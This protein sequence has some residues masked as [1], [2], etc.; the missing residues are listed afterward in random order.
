MPRS[1]FARTIVVGILCLTANA[2]AAS[3]EGIRVVAHPATQPGNT[4]YV[5]NRA[6]LAPSPLVKLPIGSIT[7]RGWLAHQLDMERDGMTGH[8]PEVSHWCK[9][10]GNAWADPK[11]TGRNGW[12]EL[13]YWL[14]G[15]IDL[16]YVTHDQRIIDESRKW[17]EAILASQDETGWFGP[18]FGLTSLGGKPDLWPN[19]PI[20]NVL[21]SYY[22]VTKDPRVLPFMTKYFRWELN[23][24]EKDF[25]VGYWPKMRGG[26]NLESIYWLYNRT[27]DAWLLDVAKKVH[28]HTANW[29]AGVA[30]WHGVNFTQSFRGPAEYWMQAK[31][32]KFLKATEADYDKAKELYGQ[33]P[34]GGFGADENARP[35][36]GD[37][38]QGFETCSI[39]EF[40]HSFEM[41]TKITGDAKWSD[42]CEELA[43]NTFPA[44][45]TPDLR[46]LHYLTCPNMVQLDPNDKSPGIQ[47]GGTMLSY[48]PGE[49]YRCCQHNV[50]MGWPYYAESLWLA[51]GDNGL[52]AS[53]Y[54]ASEVT[55]KVGDDGTEVK[56]VEETDYPFA[57]TI[58]F[59]VTTA[60]PTKFPLY[61]R[62]P[63]WTQQIG[64]GV[65]AKGERHEP[66]LMRVGSRAGYVVLDREWSDGDH[67]TLT[68]P[69]KLRVRRWPTNKDSVSVDYGPLTFS[70]KID[71]EW[72]KYGGSEKWPEFEV[73]PKSAWNYGLVLDE[74]N[75][76]ANLEVVKK[77]GAL[78]PQPFTA[79][80]T[81]IEIKAKA[82]K[83]PNWT[84]DSKELIRPLEPG[85][86]KSDAP[87]E[88]VTLIPMGAARLRISQ[89][90]VISDEANAKDWP[91]P[92]VAPVSASH[93]YG[94]DTL[95]A[96]ADGIEPKASNDQSIPRF[97]WWDH[98]G[99]DEWV[100][101][102]FKRPTKVSS[103]QIY[104]FDD[105][106]AGQCRV[107]ASWEVQYRDKADGAWKPVKLAQGNAYGVE[108]DRYNKVTFDPVEAVAVRVAVKLRPNVSG[109]ILEWKL[110]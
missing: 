6:P 72:K 28:E 45:Q 54:S 9:F 77:P 17:V 100:Q 32:E 107:P 48:S 19:M 18:R 46:G 21:Q 15:Y 5:T 53:I 13:P 91:A 73:L 79:E 2:R 68:L 75:S 55:A 97:T 37:P 44:A 40:M 25:L 82:K 81:P 11:G 92:K 103:T 60:K 65:A 34:G 83:I 12:E 110:D 16:G 47:N 88:T 93:C 106:G 57:D 36:H 43:F 4:H 59:T 99:T 56:I 35:G 66:D 102:D 63:S 31:D 64:V 20:L 104:W 70:L 85:P 8:L 10:D 14:K 49:V 89:F 38:R 58:T 30:N 96:L 52:C 29:T 76:T 3:V 42:R 71:E 109:G 86:V 74:K 50:S 69:M 27:G 84:T 1:Y 101:W 94:S 78:A 67:V 61:L 41:L 24:P 108:R 22:E 26:D 33:V 105:T 90:P 7:P 95:E 62:V 98:R 23:V 87:T 80:T 39:V 51:T